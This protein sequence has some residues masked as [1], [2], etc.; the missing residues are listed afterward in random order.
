M[1]HG[2]LGSPSFSLRTTIAFLMPLGFLISGTL[3]PTGYALSMTGR[4]RAEFAILLTGAVSLIALCVLLIPG[5][6]QVGAAIASAASFAIVNILRFAYVSLVLGFIPGRLR[7]LLPPAFGLGA[8]FL[9][10]F[11]MDEISERGLFALIAACVL[12]AFFFAIAAAVFLTAQ[13]GLRKNFAALTSRAGRA[14]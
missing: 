4:H 8:A 7:D 12:Y 14:E 6:G 10:Q 9:A 13:G 2:D 1:R 3:A 11:I 5:H